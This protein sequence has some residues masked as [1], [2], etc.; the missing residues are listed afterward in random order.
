[1]AHPQEDDHTCLPLQNP[2]QLCGSVFG[3]ER[4]TGQQVTEGSW[5]SGLRRVSI[6]QQV[7]TGHHMR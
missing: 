3:E 5:I 4:D 6:H 2:G 7:H 1:M